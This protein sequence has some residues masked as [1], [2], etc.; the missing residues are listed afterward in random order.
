MSRIV[1]GLV[2]WKNSK[3]HM[4]NNL[5]YKWHAAALTQPALKVSSPHTYL[6]CTPYGFELRYGMWFELL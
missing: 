1:I 4:S 2:R 5:Q 3:N 6:R